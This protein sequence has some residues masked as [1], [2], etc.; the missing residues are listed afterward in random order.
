VPNLFELTAGGVRWQVVPDCRDLLFGPEGLRLE[1]WLRAGLARVVKHGP[2][3]TV[4]HVAL[5]RLSFYLKHYRLPD[6][7][8]WLRELVRP[9][10][11]R[12]EFDRALAVAARRIPTITPVAVGEGGRGT[13]PRDSFL[14]TRSLDGTEPVSSFIEQTLPQIPL[15]RRTRLRQRLATALGE[16]V[17]RLHDAGIVH[18]DL[19]AANLLVRLEAD[20]LPHLFLIDLHDVGLGRPLRWRVSRANLIMLNRWFVLR[21]SR[22]DRCRFWK[23]Y[24]RTRLALH[25][26]GPTQE[27][28]PG[29][30]PPLGEMAR[31]LEERTW[32]SNVRFWQNRDRRCLVRNRRYYPL[33]AAGVAGWAVR[34]LAPENLAGLLADPDGPFRRPGALLLKD[35]PSSTVAELDLVVNGV[36][37]RVIYKRFR[38]TTCSD[39]WSALVRRTPTLRSW[40]YGHGLRERSLPTPRPLAVFHRRRAGLSY[41]GYLLTEKIPDAVELHRFVAGLDRMPAAQRQAT[42]RQRIEQVACLLREMHRRQV[43]HRDLKAGN[44]LVT[45][46]AVWLI[47]L[48]GVRPYTRLP[49]RRR[50]QNLARLHCSFCQDSRLT[51]SD[52]LRFLRTYLEWGLRGRHGWKRW[53]RAIAEATRSKIAHNARNGRPLS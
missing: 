31:D 8:T 24:R 6:L 41:E 38:V 36:C 26:A 2:H 39:P 27:A 4:Y 25:G 19:H 51:Q 23:A 17:A 44:L 12:M 32:Q 43:S 34:E 45:P 13:G 48:V 18:Q 46:E 16:F 29:P 33:R 14:I 49:V 28:D 9:A 47:D 22:A 3:R 7:R 15:P 53:W 37:H 35:S 42:L 10:K 40:I 21:S 5:P 30:W 11:A 1:E 20:D 52:K 50:M